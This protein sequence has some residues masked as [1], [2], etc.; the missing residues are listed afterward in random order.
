MILERL[1]RELFVYCMRELGSVRRDSEGFSI[2][3]GLRTHEGI[4]TSLDWQITDSLQLNIDASYA[5]HQYDFNLVAAR[6]EAFTSGNDIDTAPRWLA[7]AE[8][9]LESGDDASIALQWTTIGRYFL[10]AENR[11]SYPGH[12]LVN[13]RARIELSAGFSVTARLNNAFNESIADR[14]DYAFGNYRYIPGRGRELFV[15][16]R[17]SQ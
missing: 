8:L 5:R 13:L 7:S 15:E 2:N 9:L 10:D 11:F 16:L 12:D 1:G 14:A 4:E 17:Y 3:R 6:G